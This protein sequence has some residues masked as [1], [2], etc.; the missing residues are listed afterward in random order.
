MDVDS[1]YFSNRGI[2]SDTLDE[3]GIYRAPGRASWSLGGATKVRENFGAE[4]RER[5]MYFENG[6]PRKEVWWTHR[7]DQMTTKRIITE[8]ETDGMRL[9][10]EWDAEAIRIGA[11]SGV[12]FYDSETFRHFNGDTYFV[13]DNDGDGSEYANEAEKA[14]NLS[15]Q[16]IRKLVPN[17]K[18]IYLPTGYKDICTYLDVYGIEDF[19]KLMEEADTPKFVF[20]ALDLTKELEPPNWLWESKMALGDI[21]VV[22]AA[23]NIGKSMVMT[24][25]A[26]KMATGGGKFLGHNLI[27]GKAMIVD[28]ENPED[29]A[30]RRC[31]AYGLTEEYIPNFR[32]LHEQTVRLDRGADKLYQEVEAFKPK[33]LVLDSLTRLHTEQENDAGAVSRLFNDGIKPLARQLGV[34]VVIIHHV[35][36]SQSGDSFIRS[37]GSSDIGGAPDAGFDMVEHTFHDGPVTLMHNFKNRRGPKGSQIY[38]RIKD[39]PDGKL[40]IVEQVKESGYL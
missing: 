26:I 18:R 29:E 28:E 38:F 11:L 17:A 39:L 10:Q 14:V 6:T 24:A 7:N 32:Y 5:K 37:R 23:P 12:N 15:W 34:T 25:L 36:K 40:D 1:W 9:A 20:E 22:Q 8:G 13:F 30:R 4:G 31:Y 3:C 21:I 2:K 27:A 16:R 19:K 33:L 35:G